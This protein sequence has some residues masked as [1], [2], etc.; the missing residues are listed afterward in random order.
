M[1][2]FQSKCSSPENSKDANSPMPSPAKN[3]ISNESSDLIFSRYA[4]EDKSLPTQTSNL[5]IESDVI[6]QHDHKDENQPAVFDYDSIKE[7]LNHDGYVI[8]E[9]VFTD[10]EIEEYKC[11]FMKWY[12]NEFIKSF[13]ENIDGNGIFK[14]F[15]VSHQR[16]SWLARTN[17]KVIEIF[18]NLWD[19]DEIVTSFDGCC[20]FNDTW[21]SSKHPAYWTHTDQSSQKK[22]RHCLQSF[23]SFTDN[24]ERTLV[25]YEGSH[26]L[27]EE[28]FQ[29]TGI[30]TDVDWCVFDENYIKGLEQFKKILTVKKGSLV[31]W[32]SRTFHQNTAG[33]P[34]S[35][36]ERLVQYLCYL[37]KN[38]E[39]NNEEQQALRRHCYNQRITTAH[40]PYPM[41]PVNKQP[42]WFNQ[43]YGYELYIDY[44][45]LPKADIEDLIP[46][47][48][49]II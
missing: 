47:I 2:I 44:D 29:L 5:D 41:R 12:N 34:D 28:Y 43:A 18:K 17:P 20:Y 3:P 46:T 30:K 27:H 11:E 10:T 31:V 37:P 26:L 1:G 23:A 14:Y 22:G 39:K 13:H 40:W 16:F 25:V 6:V 48:E 42:L 7:S 49:S 32:D 24:T 9:N 8:I 4:N 21:D 15:E 35:N 36:E 33:P 19:T 45:K 38:H